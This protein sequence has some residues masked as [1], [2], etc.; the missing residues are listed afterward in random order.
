MNHNYMQ[1]NMETHLD[2]SKA[3]S[4]QKI[5]IIMLEKLNILMMVIKLF[6]DYFL[7]KIYYFRAQML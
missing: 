1:I 2:V 3:T 5:F 4:S 6:L 7:Y